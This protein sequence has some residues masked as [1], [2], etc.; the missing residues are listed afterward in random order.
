M[1]VVELGFLLALIGW[2]PTAVDISVWSSLWTLAKDQ[3]EGQRSSVANARLDFNIGYIATG[4]LAFAFLTLG[5]VVMH[6]SGET[7]DPRGTVFSTQLWGNG[8]DP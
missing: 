6:G 2:M 1:S 4:I 7:F 5:A 3:T 8:R